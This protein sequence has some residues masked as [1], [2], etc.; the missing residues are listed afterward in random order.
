MNSRID[1]RWTRRLVELKFPPPEPG[2]LG[3][4]GVSFQQA[5]FDPLVG[6]ETY[7]LILD[8]PQYARELGAFHSLDVYVREFL[9][10]TSAGPLAV[11]IWCIGNEGRELVKMEQLLN[12]FGS[13]VLLERAA[14]QTELKVVI[15]DN[16]TGEVTGFVA[17][18][19]NYDFAEFLESMRDAVDRSTP[20]D[21]KAAQRA[22]LREFTVESLMSS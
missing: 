3:R 11:F 18:A 12:P 21:F 17:I 4:Q 16:Q 19:N 14:R 1:N 6:L 10:Q 15:G 22:F 9:V 13:L 2:I 20:C 5:V 7:V 8:E